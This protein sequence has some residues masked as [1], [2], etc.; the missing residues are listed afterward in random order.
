M[1]IGSNL[2]GR[3]PS[4]SDARS[5]RCWLIQDDAV[6]HELL[7]DGQVAAVAVGDP[8]QE[9]VPGLVEVRW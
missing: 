9:V 8:T 1:A 5:Q 4:S 7:F 6:D 3:C 2:R